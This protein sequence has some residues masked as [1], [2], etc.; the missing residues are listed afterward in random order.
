M[1]RPFGWLVLG[2]VVLVVAADL[3]V[4][5][6]EAGLSLPGAVVVTVFA[7]CLAAVVGAGVVGHHG[8]RSRGNGFWRSVGSG[9]RTSFRT[10][11]DL[12]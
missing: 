11:F 9:A 3:V 6:S 10:V 1:S 2:A 5:L 7:I 4:A 12:F 8:S